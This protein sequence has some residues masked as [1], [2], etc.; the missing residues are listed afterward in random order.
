MFT[1]PSFKIPNIGTVHPSRNRHMRVSHVKR[2]DS[3]CLMLIEVSTLVA[4]PGIMV[5]G[6]TLVIC[7]SLV[8]TANDIHCVAISRSYWI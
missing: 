8:N 3:I 7:T 1:Y 4:R 6:C 5:I 2:L